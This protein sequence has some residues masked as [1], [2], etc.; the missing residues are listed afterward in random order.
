MSTEVS[1]QFLK[2][3]N[4]PEIIEPLYFNFSNFLTQAV[5][6]SIY[7][8]IGAG[9]YQNNFIYLFGEQLKQLEPC[10]DFWS[11]LI[12]KEKDFTI[13]GM[14]KMGMLLLAEN[15]QSKGISSQIYL[16]DNLNVKLWTDPNI[17]FVNLIGNWLPLKK[18]P[19]F[20]ENILFEAWNQTQKES[21]DFLEIFAI[22]VPLSLQG[23]YEASN[24]QI[25]N[26]IDYYSSTG[27][28]YSKLKT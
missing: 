26:I 4:L 27:K 21:L 1:N 5:W 16:V 2:T 25:E 9:Y 24:F 7:K 3:Y 10:I 18:I 17:V 8:E 20:N 14:N 11:F 19:L 6:N 15:L 12:P 13:I 23:K 28:I 22:K